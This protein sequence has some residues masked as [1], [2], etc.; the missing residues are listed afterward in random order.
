MR[1][2]PAPRVAVGGVLA[3]VLLVSVAIVVLATRR[4][5]NAASS[6]LEP[7]GAWRAALVAAVLAAFAAYALAVVAALRGLVE[8]RIAVLSGCAVQLL[9][10]GSPLLL[11]TDA[12][13]YWDYGRLAA[14]HGANPYS[15]PPSAFPHDPAYAAMGASWHHDTTLY[16]PLFTWLSGLVGHLSSA[17]DAQLA[18]RLLAA[19]AMVAMLA[20]LAGADA[21][22]AAIVLAGWSPLFALHFAGG[23]HNDALMLALVVG[24]A[25]AGSRRPWVAAVLWVAAVA[26]K[27]VALALLALDLLAAGAGRRRGRLA[28]LCVVGVVGV[29][30]AMLTYGTALL[31]AFR[32]LSKQSRRTGSLG[33][34]KWLAEAGL[35]H[36]AIVA[37][38]FLAT[39]AFVALLAWLALRTRDRH[40][41]VAGTG[42][43]FL[44]GWLN[45]WYALWGGATLAFEEAV[46]PA[47]LANL[48]LSALVLRD[49]LPL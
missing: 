19:G 6:P 13:T 41:S 27:W 38:L 39:V 42:L 34:A 17:H 4:V 33:L 47:V 43:A 15:T 30:L 8:R 31:H 22:A 9:P 14:R 3:T 36:R 46:V 28:R 24:A 49:A 11:S 25:A 1:G 45:P 2:G 12:Y 35:H 26:V 10:L 48:A 16:G 23:G 20:I 18:F 5:A 44:Q 32:E 40:L 7:S 21:S 37:L 29:A